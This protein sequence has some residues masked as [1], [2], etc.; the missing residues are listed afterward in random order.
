M[1]N[2]YSKSI[3]PIFITDD[4][5]YEYTIC[6]NAVTITKYLGNASEITVPETIEDYPVVT[7]GTASFINNTQLSSITLSNVYIVEDRVFSDCTG[8]I[9]VIGENVV[10][11]GA[12]GFYNCVSLKNILIPDIK[13]LDKYCFAKCSELE[14]IDI[15]LTTE[16]PD[17]IF[18]NC[19]KLKNIDISKIKT[20]GAFAFEN[21]M[22]LEEI[23]LSEVTSIDNSAFCY[24]G[25]KP[26]DLKKV[27]SIGS[28][29]FIRCENIEDIS[30]PAIKEIGENAFRS[31]G[32]SSI[33][34][35][36]KA[37]LGNKAFSSC[38]SLQ[39]IWI[40]KEIGEIGTDV[41]S[42]C[43]VN[44]LT[45]DYGQEDISLVTEDDWYTVANKLTGLD[46][47][48]IIGKFIKSDIGYIKFT[49]DDTDAPEITIL[50]DNPM[51]LEVGLSNYTEMGATV[52]D[53]SCEI[54][55]PVIS[56]NVN[57]KK[58][59]QYSATYTATDFCGNSLKVER[60]VNVIDTTAPVITLVGDS[61][62][63]LEV[64]LSKYV[65]PGAKVTDNSGEI[66]APNILGEVNT[67]KIGQY[68]V[69]YTATDSSGNSSIIKRIVNIDIPDPIIRLN[70]ANSMNLEVGV[71]T[72]I[73]PSCTAT[74]Y[75]GKSLTPSVTITTTNSSG[76]TIT[77]TSIDT[78]V[79]GN[80]YTV[81]YTV[82]DAYGG[83]SSMTRTVKIID[84]I[85]PVIKLNGANPMT[86]TLG[87]TFTDP[88]VT[89]TDK[90]G[91][92][93]DTVVTSTV[94]TNKIGS[95]TVI[96]R[97][98]DYSG[99]TASVSRTVKVIAPTK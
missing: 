37:N 7:I 32:I 86:L 97:V 59:G 74:D 19:Y 92:F 84:T 93:K 35:P 81:T 96:Y 57:T 78:K 66:L 51:T 60:R 85:K 29:A 88:G 71:S 76:E 33:E 63:F 10:S 98:S 65:E 12:Y 6:N 90:S 99:N 62:M 52:T 8:L 61:H 56:V 58:I 72:Y 30:L 87:S 46:V 73:E 18:S 16:L 5:E 11:I 25:I 4:Y 55:E 44:G 26:I 54:I 50:G 36:S 42:N 80:P 23:Y 31:S 94:N 40:A 2:Y 89:V 17:S 48:N 9:N 43:K 69:T 79:L 70:G 27:E 91:Q 45:I 47:E 28:E 14:S 38:I 3:V 67:S 13:T 15:P 34:L 39:C 22:A 77:V 20:I 68:I 83:T 95:Y 82:K 1:I 21:S 41:F 75:L 24:S 64:G 53:N 49:K